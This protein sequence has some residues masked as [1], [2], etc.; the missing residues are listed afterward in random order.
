MTHIAPTKLVGL[1][2]PQARNSVRR[3]LSAALNLIPLAALQPL[4]RA[5]P[6]STPG[7]PRERRQNFLL[8]ILRYRG[9]P[10]HLKSFPLT[11]N[12]S[13]SVLN[14]D[15]FIAERLYWFGESKGYEPEV[16]H[17][18]RRFCAASTNILELGTNIGYYAVQGGRI[19]PTARY[20]AVEPHPGAAAACRGNLLLNGI[21]NVSVLEAAAVGDPHIPF[22]ELYLPGGRDHYEEAPCSGFA[23]DNEL[24]HPGVEEVASYRTLTVHA[25][26]LRSLLPGVDLLKIDVEGQ[27]HS[28]LSSAEDL[29][30]CY[31]PSMFLEVLDGT[32]ELRRF[33]VHLCETLPYQCFV[34]TRAELIPLPASELPAVSLISKFGTRDLVMVCNPAP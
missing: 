23:S 4:R 31:K 30:R 5:Y 21:T 20:T 1:V 10:R 8:Q 32:H 34:P 12:P 15:S 18:W 28:L 9:I 26:E 25:L 2:P 14:T 13:L 17:W 19:N 27:E 3:C 22:V 29:L 6:N 33:L 24:H 11:D 16:L 7:S